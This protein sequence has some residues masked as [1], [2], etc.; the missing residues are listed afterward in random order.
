MVTLIGEIASS[1]HWDIED[2]VNRF[3]TPRPPAYFL[4]SDW[5]IDTLKIACMLRVADAGHMDGARAPTFL[6]KLLKMNSVSRAHW[7]SQNHLGRVMVSPNDATQLIIASTN[8]FSPN[9]AAAWWVAFDA[10]SLFDKE[11]RNCNEILSNPTNGHHPQFARKSVA[12]AGNI[13]ELKKYV[14]TRNW[15]P[16]NTK[17][18]VSDVASL[19]QRLGG[20][21]LY[22]TE[23]NLEIVIREL[24][25]NSSDAINARQAIVEENFEGTI[26]V[27]LIRQPQKGSFVLQVDDNGIGMSSK[28][29]TDDLMDFGKSF[30]KSTR[31]SQEFPGI[32]ASG[33]TPI[34]RFGIGFLFYLH[35]CR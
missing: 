30:W 20:A 34:G 18:H 8:P 10:I 4:D 29:L 16:T 25:Q 27:R 17:I 11:I 31:A 23:D 19:I 14:E 9:E 13:N 2:V 15:E 6:L 1:H 33:H 3:S 22:G 32:H 7:V 24:I 28:T 12:G 21:E 26:F 35:D 5:V